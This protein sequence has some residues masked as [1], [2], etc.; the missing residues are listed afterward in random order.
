LEHLAQVERRHA[1]ERDRRGRGARGIGRAEGGVARDVPQGRVAAVGGVLV[2]PLELPIRGGVA[3]RVRREEVARGRGRGGVARA[4][5]IR[6]LAL[7]GAD[8][9]GRDEGR[10]GGRRGRVGVGDGA[11][12]LFSRRERDRAVGGAVARDRAR[13]VCGAAG[14]AERVVARRKADES[15]ARRSARLRLAP[16]RA[17]D[18]DR[19]VARGRAPACGSINLLVDDERAARFGERGR[20]IVV[21]EGRERRAESVQVAEGRADDVVG[22]RGVRDARMEARGGEEE[23]RERRAADAEGAKRIHI[24]SVGERCELPVSEPW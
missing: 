20:A 13:V 11:A 1:A 22:E 15:D 18:R 7:L 8:D 19:E 16:G 9:L 14:F 3:V 4:L 5:E 23:Q 21:R 24:Y 2:A 6:E 12:R 17:L 10:L